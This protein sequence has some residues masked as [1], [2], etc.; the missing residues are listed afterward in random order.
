MNLN[1][2]KLTAFNQG[3]FQSVLDTFVSNSLMKNVISVLNSKSSLAC[4]SAA[5]WIKLYFFNYHLT[6][7]FDCDI[8]IGCGSESWIVGKNTHE[9]ALTTA[10]CLCPPS[11]SLSPCNCSLSTGN[12][13][14]AVTVT[15]VSAELGNAALGEI[16]LN[17][18]PTTPLDTLILSGN[19]LTKVPS[20]TLRHF[21]IGTSLVRPLRV[22]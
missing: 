21:S 13:S 4:I 20:T 16:L 19:N 10:V 15:C 5:E 11:P 14:T 8:K 9:L 12:D 2:N 7:N 1:N 3:V 22:Y 17:G 6:D 18:P